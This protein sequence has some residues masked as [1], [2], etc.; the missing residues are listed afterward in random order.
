MQNLYLYYIDIFKEYLIFL[1]QYNIYIF[2]I[3]Y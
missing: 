2:F 3:F 1:I